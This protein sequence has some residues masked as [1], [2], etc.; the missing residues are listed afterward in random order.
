MILA[1]T[2]IWID[3]LRRN[4]PLLEQ[5]LQARRILIHPFV[6]GELTMGNMPA[7]NVFLGEL[8]KLPQAVTASHNETLLFIDQQKLFGMGM[9][10]VD[11]HLLA[12]VRLTPGAS[13]WTRD[14]SLYA[15]AEKLGLSTGQR[16]FGL[17]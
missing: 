16:D 17:H 4:E 6:V 11:A 13:L 9:G 10:Y 14:K 15:A 8:R 7:R 12:A 1:D 5:M 2:S 3:H